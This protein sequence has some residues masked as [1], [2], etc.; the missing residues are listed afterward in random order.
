MTVSIIIPTFNAE[1]YIR[2]SLLSALAAG[3][4]VPGRWEIVAVDN[5]STDRTVAFLEQAVREHPAQLRLIHCT[6]R[7]APAARNYG[8]RHS[9]GEWLQFLDADDTIAPE[10][11]CRQLL[12]AGTA[13]WVIGAYRHLYADGS[14]EDSL[15]HPD[16]WRGLFHNYRTGHTISNLVRRPAFDRIGGW[17]ESLRSNQDPDLHF[18]LLRAGVP[19]VLDSVVGSFYY[20]HHGPRIVGS[21]P[22]GAMQRRIQMLAAANAFLID[23]R[24]E[25]WHEHAP[26]FLGAL[27]R[28]VRMLATYDLPSAIEAYGAYFGHPNDWAINRPYQLVPRY[29]RLYPYLGFRTLE[30]LRLSLAGVIPDPL[31]RMLKS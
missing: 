31:K 1:R 25:Y 24:P 23:T 18:R 29:T 13:D 15:P 7:G 21:D 5:G 22:G 30:R 14:T 9:S 3:A 2:R 10:K 16:P 11:I 26:F 28:A 27:L 8:A 12:L 20:H 19:F 17:D 4:R 6:Q